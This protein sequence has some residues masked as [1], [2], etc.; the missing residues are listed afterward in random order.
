MEEKLRFFYRIVFGTLFQSADTDHNH[1]E[2]SD[3]L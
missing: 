1:I 3:S 2:K